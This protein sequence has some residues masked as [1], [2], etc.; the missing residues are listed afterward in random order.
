M[1]SGTQDEEPRR[2]NLKQGRT[3]HWQ[4]S[5]PH[6]LLVWR[7]VW[8]ETRLLQVSLN[9]RL[10][11]VS[12]VYCVRQLTEVRMFWCQ[13]KQRLICSTFSRVRYANFDLKRTM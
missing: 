10:C 8:E 12:L 11:Y 2:R 9:E 6:L 3:L 4:H 13:L 7:F 5:H 1:A